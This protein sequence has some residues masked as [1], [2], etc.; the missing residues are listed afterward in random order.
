[1][2]VS[3]VEACLRCT[4]SVRCR[5]WLSWSLS[6]LVSVVEHVWI[7]SAQHTRFQRRSSRV[8]EHSNKENDS[9]KENSSSR[10]QQH[11]CSGELLSLCRCLGALLS[12]GSSRLLSFIYPTERVSLLRL[13]PAFAYSPQAILGFIITRRN[14]YSATPSAQHPA[15]LPRRT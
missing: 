11:G 6:K 2:F 1:M 12:D 4:A 9:N 13:G 7:H 5:M 8:G 10:V 14:E 15:A 3:S